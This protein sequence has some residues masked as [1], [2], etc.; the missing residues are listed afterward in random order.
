MVYESTPLPAFLRGLRQRSN[1]RQADLAE[2]LGYG[3]TTVSNIE[4]GRQGIG[5]RELSRWLDAVDATPEERLEA[6]RLAAT[7]APEEAPAASE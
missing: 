7:P 2:K 6:L 5:V 3:Q 4:I 1:L